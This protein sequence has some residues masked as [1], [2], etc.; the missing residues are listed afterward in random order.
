MLLEF[1]Y[2]KLGSFVVSH[3]RLGGSVG[4]MAYLT[5]LLIQFMKMAGLAFS[6]Q[7]CFCVSPL[8]SL[9]LDNNMLNL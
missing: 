7:S 5:R 4:L 9:L 1:V 6:K 8:L 2:I 3:T